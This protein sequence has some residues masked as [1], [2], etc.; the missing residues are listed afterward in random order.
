M[1]DQ[2]IP[3]LADELGGYVGPVSIEELIA[4]LDDHTPG[5]WVVGMNDPEGKLLWVRNGWSWYCD[6]DT[7]PSP[8]VVFA[9]ARN[10]SGAGNPAIYV[11][12]PLVLTF[13]RETRL[14]SEC[15]RYTDGLTITPQFGEYAGHTLT[16]VAWHAVLHATDNGDVAP[17]FGSMHV[18]V[19]EAPDE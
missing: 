5:E 13:A 8:L 10:E 16:L 4:A 19:H 14:M 9:I 17:G 15:H 18:E 12:A 6:D 1:Q 2:P 11:D 7:A 3:A